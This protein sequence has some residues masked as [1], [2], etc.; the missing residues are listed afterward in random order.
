MGK[1]YKPEEIFP[2]GSDFAEVGGVKV[3]KGS[4]GAFLKNIEIFERDGSSAK[5]KKAA[6]EQLRALAPSLIAV[7]LHRH[8]RFKNDLVEKIFTSPRG[9]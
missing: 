8:V 9:E 1:G 3:R 5:E 4:V 6:W 7:G 2:D